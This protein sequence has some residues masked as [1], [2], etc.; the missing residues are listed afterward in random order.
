MFG[1]LKAQSKLIKKILAIILPFGKKELTLVGILVL[2][3]GTIQVMGIFSIMPF[4]ALATNPES[5]LKS[6]I[7]QRIIQA[8]PFLELDNLILMVGILTVML[9]V[10]SSLIN[11][12]TDFIKARYAQFTCMR[13]GT[14]LL[15]SYAN[16]PYIFHLNHNS[17]ELVKRLQNDVNM[18]MA[19]VLLPFL[20]LISRSINVIL[21][22]IILFVASPVAGGT[23][24]LVFGSFL[25]LTFLVFR[26]ALAR[27][28]NERKRLISKRFI[29]AHQLLMGIKT[30]MIHECQKHFVSD[31][32][33]AYK[34]IAQLDSSLTAISNTPKYIIEAIAFSAI[35]IVVL[36][37]QVKGIP[38]ENVLPF[39]TFFVLAA[40]RLMPSLQLI[41]NQITQIQSK[42]FTVDTIYQD[43]VKANNSINFQ[44]NP[45]LDSWQPTKLQQSI[46]FDNLSFAYP[47]TEKLALKKLNLTIKKGQRIGIVGSSGSGKSTLIDLLIGLL[48]P[49]SG[50]IIIDGVDLTPSRFAQWHRLVGYVAQ[51]IFLTDDTIRRNIAFG[52]GD[53]YT[54][55]SKTISAA[56]IAQIHNYIV[57]ELPCGYDTPCGE[58][59]VRLSGGQRQRI[60]LARALYHQPSVL[61]F[62]EA[63]SALDNETERKLIA[64]IE[65]LPDDLTIVMVAHRL[66]TVKNCDVIY[67]M[68]QGEIIESGTYEELNNN[69]L[70]FQQLAGKS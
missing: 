39:L 34:R 20:E 8:I 67:V 11:G 59:G 54:S 5:A 63:T 28:N 31:F 1:S 70:T 33:R 60:A 9:L 4:L 35:V 16:Q 69:S 64:Q 36:V 30:V 51:D 41:Y 55:E 6:K 65:D 58:R 17:A 26:R 25:G 45:V 68:S 3:Q 38:L 49:N 57:T 12:V 29:A 10:T 21:I 62:D 2:F 37:L 50:R 22:L 53:R 47:N 52:I 61:V 27:G 15:N 7:A 44:I 18:F 42:K 48:N 14:H 13:I 19:G 56:K 32:Y 40:Y 23:A 43:L 46:I 66:S 24:F